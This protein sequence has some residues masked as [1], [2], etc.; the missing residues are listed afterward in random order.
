MG[1]LVF[2]QKRGLAQSPLFAPSD[3][4]CGKQPN[5]AYSQCPEQSNVSFYKKWDD[6]P[7]CL[8]YIPGMYS[9]LALLCYDALYTVQFS[10]CSSISVPKRV[11]DRG[12]IA[13]MWCGYAR[14]LGNWK[15]PGSNP[16]GT[17]NYIEIIQCQVIIHNI[18]F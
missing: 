18:V 9:R 15:V 2:P 7:R 8:R 10:W 17:T 5:Q 1:N 12:T 4:K 3:L 11:V 16:V 14:R 13:K 6:I